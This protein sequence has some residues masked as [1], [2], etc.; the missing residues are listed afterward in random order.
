MACARCHDHKFDPLSQKDYTALAGIFFSTKIVPAPGAKT[1]GTPVLRTPLLPPDEVK[2]READKKR[3]VELDKALAA[4]AGKA[5]EAVAAE[6]TP[7]AGEIAAAVRAWSRLKDRPSLDAYAAQKKLPAGMLRRW[8]DAVETPSFQPLGTL[9]EAVGGKA[10]VYSWR[11]KADCPNAVVNTTGDVRAITTFTLPAKSVSI[12]PGPKNPVAATWTSPVAGKLKVAGH[13]KDADPTCGDGFA[14]RLDRRSAT[15][16]ETLAQGRVANG[17]T[18][19]FAKAADKLAAVEVKVGDRIDLV[20]LPAGEYTCDTTTLELALVEVAGTKSWSL[21]NDVLASP[22][23]NPAGPWQFVEVI[24]GTAAVPSVELAALRRANA[25]GTDAELET[26]ATAYA[27]MLMTGDP[28][29][30]FRPAFPADD[31]LIPLAVREQTT[32]LR[33]ERDEV[34]KRASEPIPLALAAQEG[35]VPGGMYPGIQDVN[36]HVRGSY[37]RLGDKVPRRFPE[38]LAGDK[39]KPL[40]EVTKGSGRVE[41]AK[42]IA[43]K[44]N[45]LTARVLVNRVWA[46]HFGDGLVR[47]PGNFGLLGDRPTHPELLDWLASRFVEDGWSVKKL[48]QRIMMSATYRQASTSDDAAKDPDNKWFGRFNVRR[49]QAE[50]LR[51]SLLAVSGKLDR[52]P[53]GPAFP[54]I[55]TP[56]RTVYLRTVRSDRSTFQALFDAADPETPTDKRTV[57]TVAP[58][59]LYLLNNPFVRDR[60]KDL[61]GRLAKSAADDAGRIDAAYRLLF[62]RP[63]TANE[64]AAGVGL[65]TKGGSWDGYAH[66]LLCANEFAFVD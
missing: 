24:E 19:D 29:H 36:V 6:W 60:A 54:D 8:R 45:P 10:G 27:K 16:A 40:G 14:W 64:V 49:L 43:S 25:A 37:T 58:Q 61:A 13:A 42:W 20:V 59:A 3:L 7:R 1:A 63:P 46:W 21:T 53:G 31:A 66:V 44:G 55:K 18:A 38:I 50:E 41:L 23:A 26:A 28:A 47:T 32:A 62:G 51:D 48:H 12:H 9:T 57:S 52:T 11:G 5:A 30:P 22:K 2:K 17:G 34:A 35:G 39:Q 15:A 33:R 65:L 4:S 56:R